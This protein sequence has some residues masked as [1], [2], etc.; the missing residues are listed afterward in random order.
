MTIAA[1]QRG[2][3]L[4]EESSTKI[5]VEKYSYWYFCHDTT[6]GCMNSQKLIIEL[7]E[8]SLIGITRS[9]DRMQDLSEAEGEPSVP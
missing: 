7:S 4:L 5:G 3:R 1:N 6:R 2:S 9:M 8:V